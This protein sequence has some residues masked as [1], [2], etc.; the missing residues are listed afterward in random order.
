MGDTRRAV[1]TNN[2]PTK[3]VS[4]RTTVS[5]LLLLSRHLRASRFDMSK[6]SSAQSVDFIIGLHHT[7][8]AALSGLISALVLLLR[9]RAMLD[10]KTFVVTAQVH[11]TPVG[12]TIRMG[13]C[14]ELA[15]L[16]TDSSWEAL[17]AATGL[18]VLA[19]FPSAA[20]LERVSVCVDEHVVDRRPPHQKNQSHQD[21]TGRLEP[22]G[23]ALQQNGMKIH[24]SD[25]TRARRLLG[26]PSDLSNLILEG[27]GHVPQPAVYLS[28]LTSGSF[29][30]LGEA[31][32]LPGFRPEHRL[33]METLRLKP[34]NANEAGDDSSTLLRRCRVPPCVS[35][36]VPF[37]LSLVCRPCD[38]HSCHACL[39]MCS[40]SPTTA[41]LTR[42]GYYY[43]RY[44]TKGK[45]HICSKDASHQSGQC[46]GR[47]HLVGSPLR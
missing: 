39:R 46:I 26:L 47:G 10:Q 32:D 40:C 13:H 14:H 35:L 21:V 19:G 1:A 9:V 41:T 24:P 17:R 37:L 29:T 3:L 6:A 43:E 34:P 23:P 42:C 28:V 45:T 36:W 11:C 31:G 16:F 2:S 20:A 4:A 33:I 7:Q 22:A 12:D 38:A 44:A 25:L 30:T 15:G 8:G 27:A 5:L 18:K